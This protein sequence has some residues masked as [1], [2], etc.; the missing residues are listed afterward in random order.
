MIEVFRTLGLPPVCR[1]WL[2]LSMC[3]GWDMDYRCL[4]GKGKVC[5]K[6]RMRMI[7]VCCS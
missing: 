6:L 1:L 4:S 2:G 3:T 5:G 7:D